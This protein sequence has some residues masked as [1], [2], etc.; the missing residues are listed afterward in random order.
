M[1]SRVSSPKVPTFVTFFFCA[2]HIYNV[3]ILEYLSYLKKKAEVWY[4]SIPVEE[5]IKSLYYCCIP[6]VQKLRFALK[7]TRLF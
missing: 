2:L 3:R 1:Y 4:I 6:Y 7:V 5:I